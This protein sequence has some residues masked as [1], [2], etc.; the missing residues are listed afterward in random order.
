VAVS[1]RVSSKDLEGFAEAAFFFVAG[2]WRTGDQVSWLQIVVP[3]GSMEMQSVKVADASRFCVLGKQR[4][5][6]SA[7]MEA[8]LALRSGTTQPAA[9]SC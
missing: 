5:D 3:W 2:M 7:T 4:R 1:Q 8:T 6:A 9:F